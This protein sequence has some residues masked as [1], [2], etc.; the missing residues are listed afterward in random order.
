R[1]LAD[2]ARTVLVLEEPPDSGDQDVDAMGGDDGLQAAEPPSEIRR[3]ELRFPQ[4]NTAGTGKAK[5]SKRLQLV[6]QAMLDHAG[7]R[8][9]QLPDGGSA[10][11]GGAGS[12]GG[13]SCGAAAATDATR[14]ASKD[15]VAVTAP[16]CDQGGRN[17]H[18]G[19]G[20]GSAAA[21]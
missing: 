18:N 7:G 6:R 2:V 13:G 10:D 21:R 5:V 17:A 14:G 12:G 4:K 9:S 11:S 20:S 19:S 8:R 3:L 16:G 15:T 1:E